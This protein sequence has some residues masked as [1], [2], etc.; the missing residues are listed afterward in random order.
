MNENSADLHEYHKGGRTEH[1]GVISNVL[2][3]S[4]EVSDVISY[5]VK[6]RFKFS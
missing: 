1:G 5:Y 2:L 4:I 3:E 6:E